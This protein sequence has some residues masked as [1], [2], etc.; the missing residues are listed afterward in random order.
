MHI[1]YDR[2][3]DALYIELRPSAGEDSHELEPGITAILDA[4]GRVTG[5]EVLDAKRRLGNVNVT[6][7][8]LSEDDEREDTPLVSRA[9]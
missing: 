3:S 6:Y 1:T 7:E 2:E 4:D 9:G 5:I 8:L